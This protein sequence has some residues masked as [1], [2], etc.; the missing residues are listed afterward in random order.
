MKMIGLTGGIGSGKT[1]VG[2]MFQDLGIPVYN[3]DK[4]A[5]RIMNEDAEVRKAVILLLGK[6]AYKKNVLDSNYVAAKVFGDAVLLQ[7]LNEIVHPVVK[8]D[9]RAWASSQAS[10]YVIQEAA[11]LFENG[12]YKELDDMILITA[13]KE[14]RIDRIKKRDNLEESAILERMRHQ[15]PEEKK[16]K[17]AHFVI[18][19]EYLQDTLIQVRNIHEQLILK[20]A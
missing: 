20:H 10:P 12:G 9:F 17:L 16:M 19:N 7:K 14:I 5:R 15:W 8:K 11:I 18:H 3:S 4:E 2:L 1:T 13:P 6:N